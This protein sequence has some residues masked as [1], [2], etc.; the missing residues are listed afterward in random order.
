M[1][2]DDGFDK[3]VCWDCGYRTLCCPLDEEEVYNNHYSDYDNEDFHENY[4]YE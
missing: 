1:E 4:D 2:Y 3:Y